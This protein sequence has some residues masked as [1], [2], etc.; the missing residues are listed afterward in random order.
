MKMKDLAPIQIDRELHNKLKEYSKRSG[1]K[2]KYLTE[3][4]INSYLYKIK[5]PNGEDK[6][7]KDE[8]IKNILDGRRI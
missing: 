8:E 4:A 7:S 5:F 3:A 2:I 6:I 1:I